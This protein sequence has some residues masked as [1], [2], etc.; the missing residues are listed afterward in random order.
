MEQS[1]SVTE[2]NG[3]ETPK[4]S[5]VNCYQWEETTNSLGYNNLAIVLHEGHLS[6]LYYDFV[7]AL[8]PF[9]QYSF[10]KRMQAKSYENCKPN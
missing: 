2:Q 5:S 1:G 4:P 6:Q 8:T 7:K 3:V 9:L 10:I